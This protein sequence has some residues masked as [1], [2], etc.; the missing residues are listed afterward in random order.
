MK[1]KASE[2]RDM[3]QGE[4]IGSG[5]VVAD[6][7]ASLDS[8]GPG[9]VTF[10]KHEFLRKARA[11]EASIILVPE[12]VEGCHA[13]QVVVPN[14]YMAFVRV[15]EV[16]ERH[17]RAH[18][19][20]VHPT[21]VVGRDVRLGKDVGIGAHAVIGD[22]TVI[23]DRTVIYPNVTIGARCTIGDDVVIYSNTAL[24][25][26]VSV[27]HRSIIH[28]NCSIGGDGFG[29]IQVGGRHRKVPQ[30]GRVV[31]GND[32]EIGCNCTI[33]RATMDATRVGDGVKIDNHSH[34]A[35][36]VE[37]GENSLLIAYCRIGGSTKVGRNVLILEDVGLTNGITIGDGCIIGACAK[38]SRSWPAGSQL[39]GTPAQ[40][41]Q[42]EK[43]V[44]VLRKKLP[45]LYE[46][47]RE[48]RGQV[49]RL[50][51]RLGAKEEERQRKG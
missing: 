42:E 41:M 15:L 51:E 12:R 14:P 3:V 8:A 40:K 5:E 50:R 18:P 45:R 32:V 17:Q 38:V 25:E 26:E 33:D 13:V 30:V 9:A 1:L 47:V 20:G 49:A 11:T 34:L 4:L 19:T 7:V 24:R 35:H 22:N 43:R 46:Q 10:A 28:N 31:I 2:I 6:R 36:N 39:L 44:L 27:G 16:F 21:A 23:G 37:I 29:Y 48:L